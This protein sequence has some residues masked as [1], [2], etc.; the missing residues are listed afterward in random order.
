MRKD[1]LRCI[2][3]ML[4][5][6]FMKS[7]YCIT[8]T[9]TKLKTKSFQSADSVPN[10]KKFGLQMPPLS[11]KFLLKKKMILIY[12][13]WQLFRFLFSIWP[14]FVIHTHK[15]CGQMEKGYSLFQTFPSDFHKNED[16]VRMPI[17]NSMEEWKSIRP[18]ITWLREWPIQAGGYLSWLCQIRLLQKAPLKRS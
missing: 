4:F 3:E 11:N 9:S 6:R 1:G 15:P 17:R 7:K 12:Y 8:P 14:R 5:L 16:R 2:Y 18:T 13:I 10:Y